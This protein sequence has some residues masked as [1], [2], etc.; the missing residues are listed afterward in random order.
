MFLALP[1]CT[2]NSIRGGR[3]VLK[4]STNGF[5]LTSRGFVPVKSS[6]AARMTALPGKAIPGKKTGLTDSELSG[7]PIPNGIEV[8][9]A[10]RLLL[11]RNTRPRRHGLTD[12]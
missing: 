10:S 1:T 3:E 4:Q 5:Q 12:T 11:E 7:S 6:S 2:C 8:R 9:L